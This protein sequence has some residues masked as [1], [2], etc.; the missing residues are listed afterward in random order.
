MSINV[1]G[2]IITTSTFSNTSLINNVVF[3]GLQC[4]LDASDKNSYPGS[5]TS[6]YD[7][8][9]NGRHATWNS[10]PSFTSNGK[11]SYFYPYGNMCR[12]IRSD[13]Y[14]INNSLGYTVIWMS[15][16]NSGT[17]NAAFKFYSASSS[18]ARGIFV[19]PSWTANDTLYFDQGGCCGSDTRTQYTFGTSTFSSWNVWAITRNGDDRRIYRNGVQYI[20]N[21]SASA[22]INL[23]S[24]A[25]YIGGDDYYSSSTSSNWDAYLSLFMVYNRG[26]TSAEIYQN[27]FV[28]KSKFGI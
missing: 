26:L 4:Y 11:A 10:T 24:T 2:D 21:T 19:H 7:M 28:Q 22:N 1:N 14:G 3:N 15:K 5:G 17:A 25:L 8:S 20:K 9:G 12:G 23:D 27:Y 13:G 6:W 18:Y 16:N